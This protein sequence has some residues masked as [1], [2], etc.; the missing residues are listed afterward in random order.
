MRKHCLKSLKNSWQF[1]RLLRQGYRFHGD[2]LR[3]RY[4]RN[5]LGSVRL[6]FSVSV[7]TG[8]A[9]KRN[10]FKRRLRQF[11]V[12]K[13]VDTGFDAVIFPVKPLTQVNW[14]GMKTDMEKLVKQA[15]KNLN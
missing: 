11:S 13:K 7:K 14:S 8:N 3:A 12:E 6:G 1:R 2:V 10:L 9:V 5:T 4:L 15:E